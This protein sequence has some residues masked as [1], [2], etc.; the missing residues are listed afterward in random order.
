LWILNIETGESRVLTTDPTWLIW[1]KGQ[2]GY[3][4]C[5]KNGTEFLIVT[6]NNGLYRLNLSTGKGSVINYSA[7]DP[8]LPSD[9]PLVLDEAAGYG[10][11]IGV[12]PFNPPSASGLAR[13]RYR[14]LN[15][16]DLSNSSGPKRR[17]ATFSNLPSNLGYFPRIPFEAFERV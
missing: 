12:D 5:Q 2:M 16:F 17:L 11:V 14:H 1:S 13:P 3:F 8:D 7:G 9:S 6:Y 4:H 10:F 15:A